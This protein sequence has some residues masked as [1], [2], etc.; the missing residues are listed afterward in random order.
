M[1]LA[2]KKYIAE[3]VEADASGAG[4]LLCAGT[5]LNPGSWQAALLAAGTAMAAMEFVLRAEHSQRASAGES[6][7]EDTSGSEGKSRGEEEKGDGD[8][9][10]EGGSRGGGGDKGGGR[11]EVRGGGPTAGAGAG[12]GA[13]A[14]GGDGGGCTA[15]ALVRPPGHHAQ[16]GRADGYCFLNNA[17]LAMQLARERGCARVASVDVDVHC[18]NGTAEGFYGRRDVLTVS[19]HM[20]HGSWGPSFPQSLQT[21][22]RSRGGVL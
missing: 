13:R 6:A 5:Q 1:G 17:G 16:P 22:T 15:Y 19:L 2:Y 20:D 8:S 4:K 21:G 12:A 7:G 3:L 11:E 14:E 9:E 18:G 10:G